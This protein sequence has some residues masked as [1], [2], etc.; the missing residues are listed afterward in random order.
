MLPGQHHTR[1]GIPSRVTAIPTTT[2]GQV[3][4]GVL[5]LAVGAEP[6]LSR[7]ALAGRRSR[8][9]RRS[10]AWRPVSGERR[11]CSSRQTGSSASS[12]SK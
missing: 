3:V 7:R 6:G 8:A 11:P 4:A 10:P 5:G 9:V 2:C 12:V 1:T